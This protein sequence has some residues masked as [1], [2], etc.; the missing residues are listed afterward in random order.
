MAANIFIAGTGQH[1][2]KTLMSL[3]LVAA[4][5]HRGYRVHYM[6]PVGQR[7]VRVGADIVDE[8]VALVNEVFDLP[9][10]PK[11]GNP[12][13]IPSG[14][15]RQFLLGAADSDPLMD[16]IR[17]S[18]AV[19]ARDADIV[20]VE[21]TGHAGVG[22]V[23][24]LDNARVARELDCQVIIVTSGGIGRPIDDFSLNSRCFE[25]EGVPV[26][27]V[28][29]NKVRE[30]KLED[31]S[32]PLRLWF[33]RQHVRLLG[34][35]PYLPML[36]EITLGQIAREIGAE[37]ISGR[38]HMD[39]KVRESI[40]GAAS[41]HRLIDLFQPGVLVIMPGDRDDLVLAAFSSYVPGAE[42]PQA[43]A[44]VCLTTGLL[45]SESILRIIRG[46]Q[47]PVIASAEGTFKLASQISDLV[48]KIMPEDKK[49][50]EMAEQLVDTHVDIAAVEQAIF[51]G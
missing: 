11:A 12:V 7:T 46:S 31:V 19:I 30:S 35:I 49:K 26:L 50:L 6:K 51:A 10:P 18:F 43:G 39:K 22:S 1:S 29:S 9:T 2:G 44:A 21:G 15:T 20:V 5:T 28:I 23:L 36:A 42:V 3:G 47:M 48:A 37:I 41:P 4:L 33:Q 24:G 34:I 40:I 27:G 38:Q 8:D 13:T 45:P 17:D 14:Y 25:A 16:D 32:E